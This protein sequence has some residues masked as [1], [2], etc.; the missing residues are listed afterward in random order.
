MDKKIK[1]KEMVQ[2]KESKDLNAQQEISDLEAESRNK[3]AELTRLKN[4]LK[5]RKDLLERTRAIATTS[6]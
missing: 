2:Q 4:L 6:P 5:E 3:D 1:L